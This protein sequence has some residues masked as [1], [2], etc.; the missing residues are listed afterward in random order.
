MNFGKSGIAV[1]A[2]M[3]LLATSAQVQGATP[4]PLS[5]AIAG[6]VKDGA[7]VPQMGATVLLFNRYDRLIQKAFTNAKGDFGFDALL[8]DVYSIRITLASFVPALKKNIAI[9][10]GMKSVLSINLASVLSSIELVSTVPNSRALMSDDWIWVLRSTMSTRP[11]LRILPGISASNESDSHHSIFSET[12][13]LLKVSSGD[14]NPY[15]AINN[16][17]DLGT[18]FALATSLFGGT[19]L[20]LS[21]NFGYALA[22]AAPVAGFRTTI[23]PNVVDGPELKL[24]VQ[25]ISLPARGLMIGTQENSPALRTMTLTVMDRFQITDGLDL[26]Y[27]S[28]LESVTFLDR[29][30]YVSP[31]ARLNY[32]LGDK[33]TL[34]ASYSSGAP[35]L[36]LLNSGREGGSLEEDISALSMFPRVSL[37]DGT[38][39]VQRTQSIEMGYRVVRGSRTYSI[40]AFHEAVANAALTMMASSGLYEDGDL[41]PELSSRSS[42]FNVG[43]FSRTGYTASVTQALGDDY[44][45]TVAYGKGGVLRTDGRTLA[46]GDPDELRGLIHPAQQSWVSGKLA[47]VLPG[48]GTKFVTSYEWTDYRS[49]TPGHVYLTQQMYSEPGLNIRVRQPIPNFAGL[50]GRLEASAELRN[51]LAQG[52]LGINGSDGR[53]LILTNAPRAVRG[54]VS[55]IF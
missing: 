29:L 13:G 16:E 27:G 17:P 7:G 44:G 41:L 24:T 18:A 42:V 43:S 46:T 1:S 8:P 2:L 38:A 53:H 4:N 10:P 40:G 48:S 37:R 15:A 55:F 35:P 22:S 26:Q 14:S 9:Q 36:D 28:S 47:G 32:H 6:Y 31:F 45:L 3:A 21:G 5:G 33:G 49:L 52:Y 34:S 12:S 51:L 30:N 39:R 19:K 50:P 11:V 25:Q 23:S 54:G 20:Q